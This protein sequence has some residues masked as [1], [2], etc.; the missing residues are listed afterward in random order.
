MPVAPQQ[1]NL[2]IDGVLLG[3]DA[4]HVQEQE[5]EQEQQLEVEEERRGKRR[6]Q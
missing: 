6:C 4:E 2:D 5:Q 1:E 3:K